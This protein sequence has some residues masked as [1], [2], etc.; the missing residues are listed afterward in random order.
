ML[1]KN[2]GKHKLW[3]HR[4]VYI[5]ETNELNSLKILVFRQRAVQDKTERK[6]T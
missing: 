2:D 6:E 1:T 3:S 4:Q 5:K